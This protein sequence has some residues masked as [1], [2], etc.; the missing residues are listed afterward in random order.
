MQSTQNFR[1]YRLT[2]VKQSHLYKRQ[3][4]FQGDETLFWFH[5]TRFMVRPGMQESLEEMEWRQVKRSSF[6]AWEQKWCYSIVLIT[7]SLHCLLV[8]T[9]FQYSWRRFV[10][11]FQCVGRW[12][13]WKQLLGSPEFTKHKA[14]SKVLKQFSN[15]IEFTRTKMFH[16]NDFHWTTKLCIFHIWDTLRRLDRTEG[17][18]RRIGI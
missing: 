7:S 4:E 1:I 8:A 14:Y 18:Y 5:G 10:H 2:P 6:F 15:S 11:M 13:I 17:I 16:S 3:E 12:S 9:H